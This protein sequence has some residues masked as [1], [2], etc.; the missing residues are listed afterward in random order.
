MHDEIL[1]AE[2]FL[3]LGERKIITIL[4]VFVYGPFLR[5]SVP[6]FPLILFGDCP[7]RVFIVFGIVR[8][9]FSGVGIVVFAP[10]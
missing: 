9:V 4:R 5:A 6:V 8:I 2:A 10:A 3:I 1:V 7:N